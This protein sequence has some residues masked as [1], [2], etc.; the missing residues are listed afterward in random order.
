[1]ATVKTDDKHYQNI[2][3][4]IRNRTGNADTYKPQEMPGGI[5]QVF[6]K[7]Y[8]EGKIAGV[9]EGYMDGI[10]VGEIMLKQEFWSDYQAEGNRTNYSF[11]FA[12]DG[13]S[14]K[15]FYP[16]YDLHVVNGYQM[17]AYSPFEGSLKQQLEDAGVTMRFSGEG[18]LMNLFGYA[19]K[20]TELGTIDFSN[21]VVLYN[22]HIFNQC[23]ALK[24]IEKLIPPN[25]QTTWAAWFS[26]CAAL[27]TVIFEGVISSG[28]L[29]LSE[30]PKLSRESM[31]SILNALADKSGSSGTFKVTFGAVNLAKLSTAD[32]TIATGKGWTLA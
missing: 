20:I 15:W 6:E 28:G 12:G 22:T 1:M 16:Q 5:E 29:D 2:A 27:E 21:V 4:V 30:S 10:S 32:K 13:W 31:L 23:K 18:T 24:T 7:G 9:G 14:N 11:A 17:F 19:E 25:G 3:A 26:G 8:E